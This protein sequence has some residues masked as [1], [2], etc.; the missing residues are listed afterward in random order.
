LGPLSGFLNTLS[1]AALIRECADHYLRTFG[2]VTPEERKR[3]ALS[4]VGRY[5]SGL[6]DLGTEH[7]RYFADEHSG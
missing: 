3:R 5:N 2:A 7:D 4:I 6:P 1:V